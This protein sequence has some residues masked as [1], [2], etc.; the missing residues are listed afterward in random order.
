M[1][2]SSSDL[3]GGGEFVSEFI[4]GYQEQAAFGGATDIVLTPPQ[5]QRVLLTG[6]KAVSTSITLVNIDVGSRNV[7]VNKTFTTGV[8]TSANELAVLQS[9]GAGAVSQIL[10][11]IDETVRI[12]KTAGTGSAFAYSYMFGK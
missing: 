5:G 3:V 1:A 10:G 8:T 12:F 9:S 2:I 4:S 11:E 6:L 7:V